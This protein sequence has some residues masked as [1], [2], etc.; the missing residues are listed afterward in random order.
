MT[1]AFIQER[2]SQIKIDIF[3]RLVRI[4][5]M[6]SEQLKSCGYSNHIDALRYEIRNA[7]TA[8]EKLTDLKD[9]NTLYKELK[10]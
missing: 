4:I 1:I 3:D 7:T 2:I 5:N 8:I 10:G 6:N 9:I